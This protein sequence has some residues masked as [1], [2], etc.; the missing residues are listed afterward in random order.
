MY[1][2]QFTVQ[3]H[4]CEGHLQSTWELY[5]RDTVWI[6]SRSNSWGCISAH[7]D[8]P[9]IH[10]LDFMWLLL[11][12]QAKKIPEELFPGK[13]TR[14]KRR[15]AKCITPHCR[16]H[17]SERATGAKGV[18]YT[19]KEHDWQCHTALIAFNREINDADSYVSLNQPTT[20]GVETIFNDDYHVLNM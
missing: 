20:P 16:W 12:L 17:H 10:H 8:P 5:T 3:H 15:S 11:L 9:S 1:L 14:R 7:D 6:S 13:S 18:S 19:I 2:E 4:H